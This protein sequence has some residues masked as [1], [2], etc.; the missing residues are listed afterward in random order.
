LI[1]L[2]AGFS[3]ADEQ[4]L[5]QAAARLINDELFYIAASQKTKQYVKEHV[6]ATDTIIK[7]IKQN[8]PL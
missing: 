2:G 3:V 5:H 7:H 4:Q 1:E 8:R 6:G